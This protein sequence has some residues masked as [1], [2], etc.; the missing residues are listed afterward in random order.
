MVVEKRTGVPASGVSGVSGISGVCGVCEPGPTPE[1]EIHPDRATASSVKIRDLKVRCAGDVGRAN[2][3]GEDF[4]GALVAG[5]FR[6]RCADTLWVR[7]AV[8]AG[9]ERNPKGAAPVE[10]VFMSNLFGVSIVAFAVHQHTIDTLSTFL[11][12]LFNI[13]ATRKQHFRTVF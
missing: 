1:S 13:I 4:A 5:T 9:S 6:V 7:G 3:N 8:G 2:R 12:P 11:A 10:G